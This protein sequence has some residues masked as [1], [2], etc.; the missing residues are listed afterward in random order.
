[1]VRTFAAYPCSV[2]IAVRP[3]SLTFFSTA[4]TWLNTWWVSLKTIRSPF[5]SK[6]CWL[7]IACWAS[8]RSRAL[9]WICADM[10][11][12]SA[13][14]IGR[15]M[16]FSLGSRDRRGGEAQPAR[17]RADA[18]TRAVDA[19]EPGGSGSGWHVPLPC[20]AIYAETRRFAIQALQGRIANCRRA[21]DGRR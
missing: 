13:E 6:C 12:A 5:N 3:A 19:G 17:A 11:A 4:R 14:S 15:D 20:G 21:L 7:K 16:G 8:W 18:H 10:F 1:M 9:A 2:V